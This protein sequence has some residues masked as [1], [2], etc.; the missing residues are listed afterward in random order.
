MKEMES[1]KMIG[2]TERCRGL[3]VM[4]SLRQKERIEGKGLKLAHTVAS[5]SNYSENQVMLWHSWLRHPSFGYLEKLYP[6]L[7][8]N[9]TSKFYKCE[10]CQY[11]KHTRNVY[12]RVNYNPSRP[13]VV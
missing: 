7:F 13:F 9:K 11:P 5:S 4:K 2:S 8:A 6:H 3:Y 12:T 10:I 1:G